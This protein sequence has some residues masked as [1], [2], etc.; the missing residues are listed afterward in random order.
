MVMDVILAGGG[1]IGLSL[2][3]EL[4]SR[5]V[6]VTLIEQGAWGGEASQAAAG[7]LA[8]LKEF[9][10]EGPLFRLGLASLSLYP[11]WAERLQTET[12]IDVQLKRDGVLT[13]ASEESEIT[14]LRAKYRWQKEAGCNLAWL[15][16]DA[17]QELE[18]LLSEKLMAGIYSPEEGDVNNRLLLKALLSASR[19]LGVKLMPAT[20]ITGLASR[21]ERIIGVQ[22]TQGEILADHTVI[23]A[24]AWASVLAGWLGY[25]GVV[26]PVRGQI[27]SVSAANHPLRHVVFG[28]GIYIVPKQDDRL[29]IGATED[30]AGYCRDVTAG[31][32]I[33]VLQG[34][35]SL[36]PSL[37]EAAF[38]QAW[39]G[40]RPATF[41]G[42]PLLGP[43]PGWEGVSL[44][45][46]HFRNGILLAPI[47]AKMM[48]DW[49]V[50]GNAELLKPFFPAR[51]LGKK[52]EFSKGAIMN[53]AEK[54]TI[55]E[56][57]T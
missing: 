23:T 52:V 46:G 32:L 11:Q 50:G 53:H 54:L 36:V 33:R 31:G 9:K 51:I 1:I 10:E 37:A 7:M 30:E 2:A 56:G 19:G 55:N 24:G 15:E 35:Q 44:A 26:Y 25:P 22:T 12:G 21:G 20:V 38:L 41:D 47:T 8:P 16:K 5:G 13:V 27:A 17:L 49:L 39:A 43:V 28:P 29:I 57:R 14:D 48:A 45:A 3:H 34:V 4:A 6:T 40:L 42:L 18:P